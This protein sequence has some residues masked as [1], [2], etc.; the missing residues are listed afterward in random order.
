MKEWIKL[1]AKSKNS[2]MDKFPKLFELLKEYRDRIEYQM[3]DLRLNLVNCDAHNVKSDYIPPI[4]TK[5]WLQKESGKHPIWRCKEFLSKIPSEK[6]EVAKVNI[7]CYGC[8]ES[9]HTIKR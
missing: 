6:L 5:C 9:G 2:H 1:M 4:K 3:S 8:L 7:A